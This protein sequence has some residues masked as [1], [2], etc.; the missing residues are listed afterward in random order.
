MSRKKTNEK[1]TRGDRNLRVGEEIRHALSEIFMRGE[2]HSLDTG[3][4]SI[5]V[6]EVRVSSDLR[7]A[8]AYV[9]PLGGQQLQAVAKNLQKSAWEIRQLMAKR[10]KLQFVPQLEF[11]IDTSFAEAEKI[12]RLLAEDEKKRNQVSSKE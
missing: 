4:V 1:S 3:G 7:H 2:A 12:N 11:R 9:M 8:A 6:T 10:V 5:T